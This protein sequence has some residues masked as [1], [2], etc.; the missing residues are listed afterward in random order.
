[1]SVIAGF[2]FYQ[3]GLVQSQWAVPVILLLLS[4]PALTF[5]KEYSKYEGVIAYHYL[6]LDICHGLLDRQMINDD[7]AKTHNI[8]DWKEYLSDN[9]PDGRWNYHVHT[10]YMEQLA[11]ARDK[12]LAG[13]AKE[14]GEN[15]SRIKKTINN[16]EQEKANFERRL[17][18]KESMLVEIESRL[19]NTAPG[20][21]RHHLFRKRKMQ[22]L[23]IEETHNE[24]LA[25]TQRIDAL[26]DELQRYVIAF[27]AEN[28]CIE[29][30]YKTRS[31]RY[32]RIAT[33]KIEKNGLKYEINALKPVD[34]WI[35]NPMKGI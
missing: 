9:H 18:R 22:Y 8:Y 1:V 7:Y 17:T 10:K 20:A 29:Q 30:D 4:I 2:I 34:Y 6:L 11:G 32:A 28:R 25:R 21:M 35:N 3:A 19:K 31:D 27:C 5:I 26:E 12:L 16:I 24:I 23:A 13:V 15:C 33:Q 14:Y